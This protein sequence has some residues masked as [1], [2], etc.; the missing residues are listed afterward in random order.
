MNDDLHEWTQRPQRYWYVDGLSEIGAGA[1]IFF[2]GLFNA[3]VGLLPEG[4]IQGVLLGIGQPVLVIGLAV[5]ARWVV[6]RLKERITYPRTG[7]IAYRR[8]E[9][10]KRIG[11]IL[12]AVLISAGIGLV[13]FVS[14]NWLN[15]RWL[16][17][18][19][20]G[21]AALL[22]LIIAMRIHLLRFYI[23]AGYTHAVGALTGLLQLTE[24]H[25]TALFFG[26]LGIGWLISGAVTL[27][28]YLH[29]TSLPDLTLDDG[30]SG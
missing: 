28:G 19:T 9:P 16:P 18:I 15:L 17:A 14:R 13:V 23:L 4:R 26:S 25:D 24:P 7:Y 22:T 20:G 6:A 30:E 8:V 3:L 5:L 1:V 12:L 21:F 2:F 10:H 27:T 11:G 29:R